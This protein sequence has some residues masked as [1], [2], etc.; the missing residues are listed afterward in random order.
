MGRQSFILISVG[1]SSEG[2]RDILVGGGAVLVIEGRL[3]A[4]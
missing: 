1:M 4:P 2:I 3:R